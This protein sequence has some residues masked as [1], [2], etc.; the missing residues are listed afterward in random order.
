MPEGINSVTRHGE[1]FKI[2]PCHL[3]GAEI[4]LL[5]DIGA[6]VSRRNYTAYRRYFA[7][8]AVRPAQSTRSRY[9]NANVAL[10][11]MVDLPMMYYQQDVGAF[12][13]Y[14]AHSGA[15]LLRQDLFQALGFKVLASQNTEIHL[16]GNEWRDVLPEVS[17]GLN[18]CHHCTH[19]PWV[20]PL[21]TPITTILQPSP[22]IQGCRIH[23]DFS[24]T[25]GG[26]DRSD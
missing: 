5:V 22:G 14:M 4:L 10:L 7:Y 24:L 20:D 2:Y 11:G 12:P 25:Q 15:N 8:F 9:G 3:A 17:S 13:F 1:S 19:H 26:H 23:R 16:V 21:A 6:R 18:C